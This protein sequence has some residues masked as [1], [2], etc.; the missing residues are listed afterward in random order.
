MT[1]SSL[2]DGR[3]IKLKVFARDRCSEPAAS[4]KGE[5]ATPGIAASRTATA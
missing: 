2:R 4:V 3:I 5:Q 1:A